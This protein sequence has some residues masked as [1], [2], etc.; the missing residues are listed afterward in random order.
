MHSVRPQRSVYVAGSDYV[1]HAN[2]TALVRQVSSTTAVQRQ[3]TEAELLRIWA[4]NP[5]HIAI[6]ASPSRKI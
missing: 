1:V 3:P 5:S 4:T 6:C 2:G